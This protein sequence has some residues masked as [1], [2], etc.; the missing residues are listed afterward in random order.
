MKLN[1]QHDCLS[2]CIWAIAQVAVMD[3]GTVHLSSL[4]TAGMIHTHEEMK[5]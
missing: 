4:T 3:G 2:H 5:T 1:E